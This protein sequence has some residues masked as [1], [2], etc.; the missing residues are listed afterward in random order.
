MRTKTNFFKLMAIVMACLSCALSARG[1][2]MCV[3]GIY[4][5]KLTS[6]TVEVSYA[7]INSADYSGNITIPSQVTV[8]IQSWTVRGIGYKA[9]GECTGLTDITLPST[10]TYIGDL[11]FIRC[12]S[13]SAILVPEGVT[14]IGNNAFESCSSLSAVNLPTTLTSIESVAFT[15]CSNLR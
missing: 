14:W 11:A 10:L 3:D 15:G 7:N 13:L 1:Y 8:G 9:F 2:D 4:Y 12:S 5:T 6:S